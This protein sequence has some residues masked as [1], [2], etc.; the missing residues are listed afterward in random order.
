MMTTYEPEK[1]IKAIIFDGKHASYTM[2]EA[3]YGAKE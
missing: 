3:K 2:W 1:T